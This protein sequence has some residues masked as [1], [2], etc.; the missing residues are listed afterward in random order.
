[1]ALAGLRRQAILDLLRR[2]G[3]MSTQELAKRLGVSEA[4]I[5]RDLALLAQQG[6]LQRDH[7]G[8]FLAE[9]E[10]PYALKLRKNR[11]IKEAIAKKAIELVSEGDTVIL[12][13]GTTTLA[14]ARL[15]AGKPI[16]V[17]V[18]DV[19]LAQMLA[20]GDT[21]VLIAGG[22]VRNGFYSLV[23]SWVCEF[24]DGVRA[25]VFFMGADAFDLEG[26]TNHTFE[27]AVVKRKAIAVSRATVLLADRSK[28]GKKA[29]A[30]VAPL[31]ALSLII[32]DFDDATLAAKVPLEVVH[33]KI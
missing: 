4:T 7:G 5:R 23:G 30:F 24:L 2:F 20:K 3:G 6:L 1:M 31:A 27:E 16:R 17:I 8:A 29:P 19:P 9:G 33:A 15:M 25:D 10:L 22:M 14:L 32:T 21:E 18:L 13:S 28:W 26:V 12:D 11:E